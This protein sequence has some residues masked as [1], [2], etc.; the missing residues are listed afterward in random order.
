M[1]S[2]TIK[3][4]PN[5][6]DLALL[7]EAAEII[8]SGGIIGYPTETV[9]GLGGD[10]FNADTVERIFTIKGRQFNKALIVIVD[11]VEMLQPLI[12]TMPANAK[13]LINKFWP[14]PLTLI[15]KA[16]P[17]VSRKLSG[18]GSTIAIR[19]PDNPICL[20]LL[21][22]C[23]TPI[24]STSANLAGEASALSA[25]AVTK[26]LGSKLDLVIDGGPSQSSKPSTIV[27]LTTERPQI[28]RPGAIPAYLI[29]RM[30]TIE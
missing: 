29:E 3:I 8:K 9:Y 23:N 28:R 15:F 11:S 4:D 6:P 26:S 7:A 24:T 5:A 14:G 16:A 12:E 17:I 27:D 2:R 10:I 20:A 18:G 19:I 1:Q 25:E 22:L 30:N 13:K 21:K